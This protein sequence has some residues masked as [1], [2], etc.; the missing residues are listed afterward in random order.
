MTSETS[1]LSH[2]NVQNKLL[3]LQMFTVCSLEWQKD[4]FIFTEANVPP[5]EFVKGERERGRRLHSERKS[6]LALTFTLS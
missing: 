1:E 6:K 3:P 4:L 2:A 5:V